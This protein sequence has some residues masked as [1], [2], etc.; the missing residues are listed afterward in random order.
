MRRPSLLLIVLV[1]FSF[2]QRLTAQSDNL[3]SNDLD[4]LFDN[5]MTDENTAEAERSEDKEQKKT[6]YNLLQDLIMREGFAIDTSY[7]VMG[8]FLPGWNEAPWY[9]DGGDDW[10]DYSSNIIGAKI[11]ATIGLDIQLSRVLRV[12]QS[13]TFAIPSPPITIKEFYFDYNFKD[14]LYL[15]AGKYDMVWGVSPNFPFANLIARIPD[16]ITNP[17]DPYIAKIDI[18]VGIGGIQMLLLTRPGFIEDI[19]KP[20]LENF[21]GGIK[22]NIAIPNF[23]IDMG[24]FYFDTMPMRQFYSIKTTIFDSVEFYTEGMLSVKHDTWDGFNFSCSFGFMDSYFNNKLRVNAEFYY[25]GEGEAES[26]RRNNILTDE[27]ETFRL[28]RGINTALNI[29]FKPGGYANLQFFLGYLHSIYFNSVQLVPGISFEPANHLQ[30]Y[31]A[32]PMTPGNQNSETYYRHN[33]DTDNRPFSFVFA[34]KISGNYKYG[35]YEQ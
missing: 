23:D 8:G 17:G 35:H 1:F 5:E 11:S 6:S 32:V 22:Y 33:A 3:I 2:L 24:L 27:K 14:K 15:K 18:P 31:I 20:R 29:S 34:V 25:N 10:K 13:V 21:G 28:F 19:A 4:S 30:I 26:M 16:K 12:R 9:F 7:S